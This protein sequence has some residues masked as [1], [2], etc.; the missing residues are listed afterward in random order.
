MMETSQNLPIE[1]EIYPRMM[2][3]SQN[4]P[5]EAEIYPRMMETSQNHIKI[6]KYWRLV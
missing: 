3:T 4:L 6:Y 1:A 5:I 2:E